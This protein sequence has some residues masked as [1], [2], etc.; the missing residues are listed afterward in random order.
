MQTI[1]LIFIFYNILSSFS[2]SNRLIFYCF[3]RTTAN[4][5]YTIR[6]ISFPYS[7]FFYDVDIVQGA[8]F[9][10]LSTRKTDIRN[11]KSFVIDIKTIIK[12]MERT[13]DKMSAKRN[14]C[15]MK[16]LSIHNPLHYLLTTLLPLLG[17]FWLE[18][19]LLSKQ[20]SLTPP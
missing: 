4:A 3:C 17:Y 19:V 2:I 8:T 13:A 12:Y 6:L 7:F 5:S 16:S 20:R 15:F 10:R 14:L 9:G 11:L 18:L 1:L